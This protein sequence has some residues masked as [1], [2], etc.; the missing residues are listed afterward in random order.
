MFYLK[1]NFFLILTICFVAFIV[2][3]YTNSIIYNYNFSQQRKKIFDN[4]Q[5]FLKQQ[6]L[7]R[8]EK[9]FEQ[10]YIDAE[11]YGFYETKTINSIKKDVDEMINVCETV[12]NNNKDNNKYKSLEPL[13]SNLNVTSVI[14]SI[15]YYFLSFVSV[16][17]SINSTLSSFQKDKSNKKRFLNIDEKELDKK[18]K[19]IFSKFQNSA[20]E[21]IRN[22]FFGVTLNAAWSTLF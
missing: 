18:I 12:L 4:K 8:N 15:K 13:K 17:K 6:L 1:D 10:D 20:L 2:L 5:I 22:C 19:N 9:L 7:K 11:Q 21:I 14:L 16:I 3:T